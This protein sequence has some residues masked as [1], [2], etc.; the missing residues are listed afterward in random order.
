MIRSTILLLTS[1]STVRVAE[2]IG[3]HYGLQL[4]PLAVE[5]TKEKMFLELL[6]RVI[7][8]NLAKNPAG[9][10]LKELIDAVAGAVGD[11]PRDSWELAMFP[12]KGHMD[13]LE[14]RGK[15]RAARG[16]R[17]LKWQLV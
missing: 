1:Q 17:P 8:R 4:D 10:T 16:T 9:L 7:L 11:W 13:R 3:H 5:H 2:L 12:V 6:D 14:E 15:V